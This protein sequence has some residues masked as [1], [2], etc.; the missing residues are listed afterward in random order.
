MDIYKFYS[1]KQ[2]NAGLNGIERQ[3]DDPPNIHNGNR[4]IRVDNNLIRHNL[5]THNKP[6]NLLTAAQLNKPRPQ[7]LPPLNP[8]LRFP[9]PPLPH[10]L[11]RTM[12]QVGSS[13]QS[14]QLV[15]WQNT[16]DCCL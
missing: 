13:I 3:A 15:I 6:Q 1:I 7:T 8:L 2:S 4:N 9:A 10:S 16:N 12:E 14:P 11:Q 5:L